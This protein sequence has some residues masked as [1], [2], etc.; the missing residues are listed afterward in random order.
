MDFSE[1]YEIIAKIITINQSFDICELSLCYSNFKFRESSFEA[2][3][4]YPGPLNLIV[5]HVYTSYCFVMFMQ[6]TLKFQLLKNM[7]KLS[8]KTFFFASNSH[9]MFLLMQKVSPPRS[10]II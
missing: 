10:Y 6:T 9:I 3:S 8:K 7:K 4:K 1:V 2:P 5:S